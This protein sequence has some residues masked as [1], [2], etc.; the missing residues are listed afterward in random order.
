MTDRQIAAVVAQHLEVEGAD[1][2]CLIVGGDER[3]ARFRH[4]IMCGDVPRE[5]LMVVLVARTQGLHVALTR[6]ASVDES[7]TR[8]LMEKCEIVNAQVRDATR[9]G[10]TWGEV[11]AAL[12]RGYAAV[13]QPDA[14]REHFQG[15]PIGYGQREFE[16][17]PESQE[18]RWWN[19]AIPAGCA[20][21]FNPSLAGGAKIEDTYVVGGDSL[22]CVTESDRWP[23]LAGATSGTAVLRAREKKA[24]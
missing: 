24:T 23:R 12:G 10:S 17:S 3:L 21:A 5:S 11:Y 8:A 15:G 22:T 4:P 7:A 6:L 16:L 9:V 14:W 1:A 20:T 19:E 13:G 18:S 2:V